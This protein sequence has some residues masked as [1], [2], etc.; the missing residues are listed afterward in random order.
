MTRYFLQRIHMGAFGRFAD[1]TVGPFTDGLNVVYGRN[2]SGKT[3]SNAFVRGVL[4]GWEDARGS[5]NV[6]KPKAADRHG[7]LLFR[8][9]ETGEVAEL[10]RVKNADGLQAVPPQAASIAKDIDKD[11][12]ATVFSLDSDELRDFDRASDMTAKILT[13]GSGTAVSPAQALVQLDARIA[14][15]T[16]KAASAKHSFPNLKTQMDECRERMA[17]ARVEADEFK[18]ADHELEEAN[19]ASERITKELAQVN[20]RIEAVAA[21]KG[22]IDRAAKSRGQLEGEFQEIRNQQRELAAEERVAMAPYV[23]SPLMDVNQE[24]SLRSQVEGMES[25]RAALQRRVE[26]ARDTFE[27]ARARN[28]SLE[29]QAIAA[30]RSFSSRMVII[31]AAVIVAAFLVAGVVLVA[32][33]VSGNQ[34]A[35]ALAG[36]GMLAVSAL[37][38]VAALFFMSRSRLAPKHTEHMSE[39]RRSMMENRL[40]LESCESDL[41]VYDLRV[42]EDLNRIGLPA[43]SL[44][45]A[46]AMLDASRDARALRN[47]YAERRRALEERLLRV[48]GEASSME[49]ARAEAL[50]RAEMDDAMSAEA[51]EELAITL[52]SRRRALM[53]ELQE[54]NARAGELKQMLSAALR[55]T[56]LDDLKIQRAQLVTRQEESADEL[57]KLLLARR[58]LAQALSSWESES[59]PEVYAR[60]SR[61]L[62]IM[63]NGVW[64]RIELAEDGTLFAVNAIHMRREPRYLSIG[65]CQQMYLALRIALLE[66]A[67]DVGASVPVLADDILV[68]FDDERRAGAVRA[69]AELAKKRQV[70][71]FTCHKEV[72]DAFALHAG[73]QTLLTL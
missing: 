24:M 61:L 27:S 44:R 63:T 53:D 8:N 31:V 18:E 10:S 33:G 37:L 65:T 22:E 13:A 11:T 55:S 64:T 40:W 4:F 23:G 12:F 42:Q 60:A 66:S 20:A 25:E 34:Q 9:Q 62:E 49:S 50:E 69:L 48:Q 52:A 39:A 2:E 7:A 5:K 59:Q 21:C 47:V 1:K 36:G 73:E 45:H 32:Q 16:S 35:T 54:V 67:P 6:Y 57:A 29:A 19:A 68:N 41:M 26:Q 38:A 28:E 70:I 51:L 14:T 30:R 71:V 15:F 43:G 72:V 46:K 58:L 56:E 17:F 3:T